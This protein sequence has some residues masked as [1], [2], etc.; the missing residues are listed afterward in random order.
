MYDYCHGCGVQPLDC[1][2]AEM[3]NDC[4]D[5]LGVMPV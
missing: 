4:T 3:V 1:M 5:A 2:C